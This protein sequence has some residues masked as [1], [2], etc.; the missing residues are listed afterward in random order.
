MCDAGKLNLGRHTSLRK[1]D[2]T[3]H[4]IS[5]EKIC[6]YDDKDL[7]FVNTQ[8]K[9]NFLSPNVD[10]NRLSTNKKELPAM[11]TNQLLHRAD[12]SS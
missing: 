9:R 7:V 12:S 10:L 3:L 4:E 5:V 11:M 6:N 1:I 8:N 2:I